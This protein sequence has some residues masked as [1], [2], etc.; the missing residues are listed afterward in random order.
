MDPIS[1]LAIAPDEIE[2]LIRDVLHLKALPLD[3]QGTSEQFFESYIPVEEVQA[4]QSLVQEGKAILL[5]LDELV[6]HEFKRLPDHA[7]NGRIK[8]HR[9]TWMR[10]KGQVDSLRTRSKDPRLSISVQLGS[11][12]LLMCSIFY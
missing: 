10:R 2:I 11:L 1:I 9:V 3:L 5:Q 8:V 6:E 12:N 4:F 7:V